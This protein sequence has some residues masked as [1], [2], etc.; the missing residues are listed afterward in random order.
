MLQVKGEKLLAL[1]EK[2]IL[3]NT[4]S[5]PVSIKLSLIEPFS[6]CE[7]PGDRSIEYKLL[8]FWLFL[9]LISSSTVLMILF[10]LKRAV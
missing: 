7:T 3:K 5:L 8:F 9:F 6:L 4:S 1:Y 10:L 2:L